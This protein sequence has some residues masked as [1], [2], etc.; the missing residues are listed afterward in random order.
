MS[1]CR[2]SLCI[3]QAAARGNELPE[4][5]LLAA[6]QSKTQPIKPVQAKPASAAALG[7]SPKAERMRRPTDATELEEEKG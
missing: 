4:A 3:L 6:L 5:I 1:D 7:S 2:A